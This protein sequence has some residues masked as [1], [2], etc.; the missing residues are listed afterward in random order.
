MKLKYRVKFIISNLDINELRDF[1]IN[2]VNSNYV[3]EFDSDVEPRIP[4]VKE[5]MKIAGISFEVEKFETEFILEDGNPVNIFN[6]YIFDIDKKRKDEEA[7]N[8]RKLL[9][10][11]N[12]YKSAQTEYD[13][14]G[15]GYDR[16]TDRW[17]KY[18]KHSGQY[19]VNPK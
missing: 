11:I 15:Y 1:K 3:M 8:N 17:D 12:R 7:E 13:K 4:K 14:Y 18:F 9:E 5:I 6:V 19:L 16:S 2:L 10:R